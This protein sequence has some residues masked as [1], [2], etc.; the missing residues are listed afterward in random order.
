MNH[1][2][3]NINS[4]FKD[5]KFTL[6]VGLVDENFAF[7]HTHIYILYY[8]FNALAVTTLTAA[9]IRCPAF[10][11]STIA[12]QFVNSSWTVTVTKV[13][14]KVQS[15]PV[16]PKQSLG[17]CLFRFIEFMLMDCDSLTSPKLSTLFMS[18]LRIS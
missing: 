12:I 5:S 4:H 8:I 18:I 9:A 7:I 6:D 15:I 17:A 10:L 13:A 3:L 14:F 16:L 1:S 2:Q 11:V